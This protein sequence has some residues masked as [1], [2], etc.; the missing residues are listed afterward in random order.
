M[1]CELCGNEHS[2]C[3]SAIVDGVEMMLCQNC[4]KHGKISK[5]IKSTNSNLQNRILSRIK[6][7]KEKDVY[8]DMNRELVNNF[9]DLI[10]IAREKRGLSREK[11]GFNI[12]E[13]TVT[14]AKI[15][16]GDLRPSDKIA[17]KLEKELSITLFEEVKEISASS[18]SSHSSGLT[19][20]DFVRTDDK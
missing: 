14:I 6:R 3:R 16:K 18:T 13:R 11:L 12:G 4:V 5:E 9:G 10:K 8:K 7:Q 17:E 19:L 2:F 15:E 1:Q 20:G